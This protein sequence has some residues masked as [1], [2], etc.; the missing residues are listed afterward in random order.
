[1]NLMKVDK[2]IAVSSAMRAANKQ[3]ALFVFIGL[4]FL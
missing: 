3:P 2:K 1:M 4:Y